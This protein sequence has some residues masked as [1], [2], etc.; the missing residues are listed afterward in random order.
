MTAK[1]SQNAVMGPND[2]T[3]TAVLLGLCGQGGGDGFRPC[4]LC[5]DFRPSVG[6]VGFEGH[7]LARGGGLRGRC[8]WDCVGKVVGRVFDLARF[9]LILAHQWG[10]VG[11]RRAQCE[12]KVDTMRA[13]SGHIWESKC[14][15]SYL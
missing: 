11:T 12:H 4:P 3:M 1:T 9:A 15:H 2:G 5:C 13:Q 7:Y 14:P 8:G 6:K 10:K